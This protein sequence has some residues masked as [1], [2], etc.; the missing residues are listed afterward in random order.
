MKTF[1]QFYLE[2]AELQQKSGH[3]G[4]KGKVFVYYNITLS[5]KLGKPLFSIQDLKTEKVIGHSDKLMIRDAVLKVSEAGR[6]RVNVQQRKNVHAGIVGYISEEEP[7]T[8]SIPITYN[9]YKHKTFVKKEDG[10]PVHK[11]KLVSLI[12]GSVTAENIE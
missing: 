3:M 12:D 2:M 8:L 7:R 4:F 10:T 11:A 6:K 5:E 1:K 9:P